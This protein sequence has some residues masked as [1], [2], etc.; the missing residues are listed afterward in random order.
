MI[1]LY[2]GAA[3]NPT[4]WFRPKQNCRM[5]ENGLPFCSVCAEAMV[6]S[7]YDKVSPIDSAFPAV[8]SFASSFG[9]NPGLRLVVK[10]PKTHA[11][12][13]EWVVDGKVITAVS[14]PAPDFSS[15]S[16]GAHRVMARVIDTSSAIRNDPDKVARDSTAWTVQVV[17]VAGIAP[18][19]PAP[20]LGRLDASGA[21][22][23]LPFAESYRL[24]VTDARGHAMLAREGVGRQG[25]NRQDWTLGPGLYFCEVK[26]GG[27][28]LKAKLLVP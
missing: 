5:R 3:Y 2:E 19:A 4:G 9:H 25:W 24:R 10:Q 27:S 23:F 26:A 17:T 20:R 7:I 18:A 15:L 21:R 8:K 28:P 14:G 16:M 12:K 13:I 1:G 6:L 22:F 11:L